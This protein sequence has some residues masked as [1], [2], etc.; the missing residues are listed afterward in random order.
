LVIF[1]L[2]LFVKDGDMIGSDSYVFL[3]EFFVTGEV[4]VNP[5]LLA[6]CL[7]F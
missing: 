7:V 6:D 2:S 5:G 1:T 3:E 4:D